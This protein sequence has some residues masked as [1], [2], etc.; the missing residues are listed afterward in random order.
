MSEIQTA[1]IQTMAKSEQKE[2]RNSD[3]SDFRRLGFGTTP[4]LFEIQT[5]HLH[6]NTTFKCNFL[7]T[8]PS[9]FGGWMG[10]QDLKE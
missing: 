2:V 3:S 1:E 8:F 4:Q 7:S 5:G 9:P 6:H 10:G